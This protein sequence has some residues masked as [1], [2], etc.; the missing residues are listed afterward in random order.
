MR[1]RLRWSVCLKERKISLPA[2]V[3]DM[4]VDI[5]DVISITFTGLIKL[6]PSWLVLIYLQLICVTLSSVLH[7]QQLLRR[8]FTD[9]IITP[10]LISLFCLTF[11]LCL[12]LS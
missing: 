8:S 7:F 11:L 1:K 10:C 9:A 3:R 2:F 12:G 4:W 6:P 5:E